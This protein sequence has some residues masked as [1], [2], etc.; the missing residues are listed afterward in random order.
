LITIPGVSTAMRV[1]HPAR[2]MTAG[3]GSNAVI[4]Q[5]GFGTVG[6]NKPIYC[7]LV[8]DVDEPGDL[9]VS[10]TVCDR[11][12]TAIVTAQLCSVPLD[13][14]AIICGNLR[15]SGFSNSHKGP[16]TILLESGDQPPIIAGPEF[17]VIESGSIQFNLAQ[18][19]LGTGFE[20]P[21]ADGNQQG[22]CL[23]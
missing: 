20:C 11:S 10:V 22:N 1:I 16:E 2:C 23:N 5:S 18:I 21:F 15:N 8:N 17:L 3:P 14:T 6:T 9:E 12:T 4:G 19:C 7:P 13:G